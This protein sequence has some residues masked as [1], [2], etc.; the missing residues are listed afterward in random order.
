VRL[1]E[2]LPEEELEKP[3]VVLQ[4]VVAVVLR[5]ALVALALVV[6]P[7]AIAL[8]RPRREQR[9]RRVDQ[10]HTVHTLRVPGRE[11][12]RTQP[13]HRQPGDARGLDARSI[14]DGDG[15]GDELARSISR[16]HLRAVR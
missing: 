3:P 11:Q 10:E 9:D 14:E 4:P 5:P 1:G 16:R 12:Q 15:V 13:A 8:R 6:E 7:E 2:H